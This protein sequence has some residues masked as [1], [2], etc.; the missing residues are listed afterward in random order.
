MSA[1][2]LS[3][4]AASLES[5]GALRA[6]QLDVLS[7]HL[8]L[9]AAEA[10]AGLE[11]ATTGGA[12]AGDADDA[13]AEHLPRVFSERGAELQELH[14]AIDTLTT[15]MLEATAASAAAAAPADAPPP[16][17]GGGGG[18]SSSDAAYLVRLP[19]DALAGEHAPHAHA[20]ASTTHG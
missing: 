19:S 3:S 1:P 2:E 15:S 11:A 17:G 9:Q 4:V 7:R 12:G 14:A 8:N 18:G 20:A 5:L 10:E 13:F 16:A 6:M